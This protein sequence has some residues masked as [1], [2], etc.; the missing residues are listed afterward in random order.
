MPHTLWLILAIHQSADSHCLPL[1]WF[2]PPTWT[3]LGHLPSSWF[4]LLTQR[5]MGTTY[6]V[7]GSGHSGLKKSKEEAHC[8]DLGTNGRLKVQA[9]CRWI[10]EAQKLTEALGW[11]LDTYEYCRQD[12]APSSQN[13]RKGEKLSPAPLLLWHSERA[14]ELIQW[15][16][17][18]QEV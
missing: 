7:V 5:L 3:T 1:G 8:R 15:V 14:A 2:E 12:L 10:V 9:W 6:L 11:R 13:Q 17:S 16:S 4:E 18:Q